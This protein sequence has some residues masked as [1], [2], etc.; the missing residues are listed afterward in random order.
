MATNVIVKKTQHHASEAHG[1]VFIH[2]TSRAL[3]PH[4]EWALARVFGVQ[5]DVDWAEQPISP[6]SLRAQIMWQ[7]PVGTGARLASALVAFTPVRHE[8]TEDAA[9]GRTGE[10]FS[11]TPSLGLFRADIG[12]HG[13]VLVSEDR[14]RNAVARSSGRGA[15]LSDAIA[16][17]IGDPWDAELEPFRFAH[18]GSTVRV[19]P[20]VV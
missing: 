11:A 9:P 17:L 7:G 14:L 1:V 19:L 5:V 15:S 12:P 2:S 16:K 8:V 10:R 6:G 3:C 18:E 13:D 4:L 20:Q